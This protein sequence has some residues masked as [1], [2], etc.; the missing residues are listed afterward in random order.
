MV[1]SLP[2]CQNLYRNTYAIEFCGVAPNGAT[3]MTGNTNHITHNFAQY[4]PVKYICHGVKHPLE[5]F[6][7]HGSEKAII[8]IKVGQHLLGFLPQTLR[9]CLPPLPPLPW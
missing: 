5:P 6:H 9:A 1:Q 2:M 8:G 4:N 3:E 7:L